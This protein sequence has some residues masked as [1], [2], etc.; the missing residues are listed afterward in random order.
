L[1]HHF[2]KK[3][4]LEIALAKEI[5]STRMGRVA[6]DNLAGISLAVILPRWLTDALHR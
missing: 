2:P 5:A 6:N 1:F 3:T 4:T